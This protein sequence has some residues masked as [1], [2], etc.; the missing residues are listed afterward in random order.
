[1][2]VILSSADNLSFINPILQTETDAREINQI[3]H[4]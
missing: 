3:I 4:I 1:M 2:H